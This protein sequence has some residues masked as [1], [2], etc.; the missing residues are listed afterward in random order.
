M[1][2]FFDVNNPAF[3]GLLSGL[4]Q[5][6]MPSR[7]PI[8]FGGTI[9]LAAQGLMQGQNQALDYRL[10]KLQT[11]EYENKLKEQDQLRSKVGLMTAP[12]NWQPSDLPPVTPGF[13]RG[14]PTTASPNQ[15]SQFAAAPSGGT[16]TPGLMDNM[17]GSIQEIIKALA[18]TSP[19]KAAEMIGSLSM[20]KTATLG[21]NQSLVQYNPLGGGSNEPTVLAKGT[22]TP[23]TDFGRANRDLQNGNITPEQMQL[24]N[25]RFRG[26]KSQAELAQDRTQ[27]M[28][29]ERDRLS[30]TGG[31]ADQRVGRILDRI[32]NHMP[33]TE[34]DQQ[35]LTI[36]R[37]NSIGLVGGNGGQTPGITGFPSLDPSTEGYSTKQVSN[38]GGMTQAAID[39]AALDYA[40]T[41]RFPAGMGIGNSGVAGQQ[42]NAVRNRAGEF[43]GNIVA[44]SVKIKGLQSAY[45]E[46]TKYYETI[47]RS[48][49]SADAGLKQIV[50]DFSG[51][52]NDK[53]M[54]I[55]N[56]LENAAK[57]QIDPSDISSFRAQL[58]ELSNEYA[59]VFS[60]NGR[61]TDQVRE[62]SKNILDGNISIQA[63]S[64]VS[65][66]LQKQGAIIRREANQKR[67]DI[68][69]EIRNMN[70]QASPQ[71]QGAAPQIPP[72]AIRDLK[73]N[74][75]SAAQFEQAFGL[76]PGSAQQY[77]GQ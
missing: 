12:G 63:L 62:D 77:L 48:I 66:G 23:T 8:G 53:T 34:E 18:I 39:Q 14:Q 45:T 30:V 37:P 65:D 16:G 4:G 21:E 41:G 5:A 72:E 1:P 43:G 54:P 76:P 27:A 9:G 33:L 49:K 32:Q 13:Q 29:L 35:I 7:L 64:K 22:P 11:D 70:G 58:L 68:L 3:L 74:P 57:Y 40:A 2:G 75:S 25:D 52:V 42:K 15:Q 59:N 26:L 10:K 61:M 31:T 47:D 6:S 20:P 51:I 24:M 38:T 55:R 67:D 73:M 69:G 60:R 17:P 50:E 71:Q 44:N 36:M 28:A 56:I 46:Q 19:D